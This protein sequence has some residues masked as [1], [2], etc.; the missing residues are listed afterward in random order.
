MAVRPIDLTGGKSV[1]C[2]N[3]SQIKSAHQMAFDN[4]E[5]APKIQAELN[6]LES[7]FSRNERA[8]LAFVMIDRLL[9][10][11]PAE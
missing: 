5:T 3:E 11:P 1:Y 7:E 2:F 4:P 9:R 6:R 10:T 8:A